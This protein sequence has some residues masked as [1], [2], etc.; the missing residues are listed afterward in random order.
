MLHFQL[1]LEKMVGLMTGH[2][3]YAA[4]SPGVILI[5]SIDKKKKDTQSTG[6]FP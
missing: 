5:D 3:G 6:Q 1:W 4:V 2:P